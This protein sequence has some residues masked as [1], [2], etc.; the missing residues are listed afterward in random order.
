MV[1]PTLSFR[2][3]RPA[4]GWWVGVLGS[5]RGLDGYLT[6]GLVA[7]VVADGSEFGVSASLNP[8]NSGG[9]IFDRDGRVLGIATYKLLE[10]ESLGFARS[11][12]LLCT[13]VVKC[14]SANPIWSTQLAAKP[15]N[16][17]DGGTSAGQVKS[18]TLPSFSAKS[19]K[20]S[21]TQQNSINRLLILNSWTTKFVCS[22]IISTKASSTDKSLATSR[23]K[24]ACDFARKQNPSL[25]TFYQ[26]K[27]ST[28]TS[29]VGKVLVTLK[30]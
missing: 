23:A 24:A 26:V 2:G 15:G 11:A 21:G 17:I 12:T 28:S 4:Q 29:S 16:Q 27:T 3:E 22:G 18:S 6:T 20:L 9:P 13:T 1:L 30:N 10:S 5:P 14:D 8:G 19:S 7:K 25:S